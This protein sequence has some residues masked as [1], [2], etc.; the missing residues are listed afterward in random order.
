[1]ENVIDFSLYIDQ[2]FEKRIKNRLKTYSSYSNTFPINAIDHLLNGY[3][4]EFAKQL[5]RDSRILDIGAGSGRLAEMLLQ[6]GYDDIHGLDCRESARD[7]A[8]ARCVYADFHLADISQP[9]PLPPAYFD[10]IISVGPFTSSRTRVEALDEVL[11]LLKPGG[12]AMIAMHEAHCDTGG[13][14]EKLEQ[15]EQVLCAAEFH[16]IP[17]YANGKDASAGGD[18]FVL[19]HLHK[20]RTEI[21]KKLGLKA[22]R[23][24]GGA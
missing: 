17:L 1:M 22:M 19:V 2:S 3:V 16:T 23:G 6:S 18:I 8:L 9:V 4:A 13:F 5:P 15:C 20:R 11:R 21:S 10:C 14:L 12:H 7:H 24:G